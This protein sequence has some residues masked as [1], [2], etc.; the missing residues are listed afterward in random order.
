MAVI[1]SQPSAP[2]PSFSAPG[3]VR[4]L[5]F[6]AIITLFG[7]VLLILTE[8]FVTGCVALLQA[9]ALLILQ[10]VAED[11]AYSRWKLDRLTDDLQVV[12]SESSAQGTERILLRQKRE[13]E[14]AAAMAALRR[15]ELDEGQ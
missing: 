7:G 10:A 14:D 8:Q 1:K 9:I 13:I 11:A 15:K 4:A 2:P 6:L 12:I 5:G 3:H